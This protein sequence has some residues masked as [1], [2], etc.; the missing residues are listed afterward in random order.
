MLRFLTHLSIAKKVSLAP[1]L[2]ALCMLVVAL[3]GFLGLRQAAHTVEEMATN[4][5]EGVARTTTVRDRLL[6]A[7]ALVMQSFAY[8]GAGFKADVVATLDRRIAEDFRAL[9]LAVDQMVASVPESDPR[10]RTTEDFRALYKRYADAALAALDMKPAGLAAAAGVMTTSDSAFRSAQ[11]AL[12]RAVDRQVE[13]ARLDAASAVAQAERMMWCSAG[14]FGVGVAVAALVVWLAVR[15]IASPLHL[16]KSMAQAVAAGDLS[17]EEPAASRDETGAVLM[18][19]SEVR[20]R[21]NVMIAGIRGTA[22]EIDTA[23]S[24]IAQGNAD[25]SLRTESTAA[26]LQQ[27]AASIEQLADGLQATAEAA[28]R[29]DELSAHTQLVVDQGAR[30]VADVVQA[31]AAIDSQARR[32]AEIVGVIDA[33]A[34][35]TNILALNAAV[36]AARAG[37]NGR[38]FAVVASEVRALAKRSADA[39][40]EIK[41]LILVS[42]DQAQAGSTKVRVAGDVMARILGAIGDVSAMIGEIKAASHAQAVSVSEVNRAVQDMDTSTQQNAALVEQAA[43]ATESLKRQSAQLVGAITTFKLSET[44]V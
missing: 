2:V 19:L 25:L 1:S 22:I 10:R 7:H 11:S 20:G 6:G 34:F 37:E 8:E 15:M 26:A 23:S 27:T 21:L 3:Q 12:T 17:Q 43:A 35:R 28:H 18:A 14:A 36:E 38:G 31:M 9:S 4:S 33:I 30:A 5:I 41:E 44:R 29:V 40:K 13:A 32:I 42:A 24:E 16:A 39:S